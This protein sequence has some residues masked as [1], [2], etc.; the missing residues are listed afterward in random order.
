MK[1]LSLLVCAITFFQFNSSAQENKHELGFYTNNF[2]SFHLLYKKHRKENKYF[3]TSFGNLHTGYIKDS[4]QENIHLQ[5]NFSMGWERR[6]S[7]MK[8]FLLFMDL[9][10]P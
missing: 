1:K 5:F 7:L 6:N 2:S 4:V 9:F 10:L 3:R 8:N